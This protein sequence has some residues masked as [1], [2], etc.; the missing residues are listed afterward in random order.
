MLQPDHAP[1]FAD[2]SS[3]LAGESLLGKPAGSGYGLANETAK[4][5]GWR[6]EKDSDNQN[7]GSTHE[8]NILFCNDGAVVGGGV[9]TRWRGRC[10]A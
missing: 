5:I 6:A 1:G 10:G 3:R 8:N 2:M 4:F 9:T 7:P